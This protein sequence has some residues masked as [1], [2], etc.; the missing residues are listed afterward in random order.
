[1]ETITVI[2]MLAGVLVVLA[3]LGWPWP[4]GPEHRPEVDEREAAEHGRPLGGVSEVGP[5]G[6]CPG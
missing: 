1:M 5:M 2:L 4:L 3:I 6:R